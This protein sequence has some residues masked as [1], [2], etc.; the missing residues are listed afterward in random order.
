MAIVAEDGQPLEESSA[1]NQES[2]V[3][4]AVTDKRVLQWMLNGSL[5]MLYESENNQARLWDVLAIFAWLNPDIG[6]VQ[7]MDDIC[8]PMI[9]LLEDEAD[10]FWCFERAMGRVRE[11]TSMGVQTQLGMLSQDLDGG[12]FLFA[13][14]MLMVLSRKEF[15]FL[16]A[17]YLWEM[18]WAME[19][20][21][22][23]FASY[24]KTENGTKQ[25]PR[26]KNKRLLKEAKGLDDVVQILGGKAC[27][28]ALKIHEKFLRKGL[29]KHE[30]LK[31]T[32]LLLPSWGTTIKF[33]NKFTEV[34]D[35]SNSSTLLHPL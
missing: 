23:K 1:E 9:I 31:M 11:N 24:K 25:D 17:F 12:E 10:A 2:L 20:N 21:T 6:Y 7:G 3:K 22:N 35:I 18:M 26:T 16:D 13:I 30:V 34:F 14:R 15:S 19:Y 5:S 29:E 33:S 32:K 27:K 8:S 28:E 4:T